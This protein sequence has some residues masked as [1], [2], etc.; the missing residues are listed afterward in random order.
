MMRVVWDQDRIQQL[1]QLAA[2][3]VSAAVMA[4]KLGVTK[5]AVHGKLHRL[6][7]PIGPTYSQRRPEKRAR[8]R[9]D[10][11]Q[12]I[13]SNRVIQTIMVRAR[14]PKLVLAPVKDRFADPSMG[15]VAFMDLEPGMCRFPFGTDGKYLFCGDPISEPDNRHCSYCS[16]HMA[17]ARGQY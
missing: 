4:E 10:K 16:Q 1:M 8:A 12:E 5:N 7:M 13:E 2:E 14:R 3:K 11:A 9:R 17:I 6:G 15:R